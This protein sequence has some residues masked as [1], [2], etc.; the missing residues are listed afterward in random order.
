MAAAVSAVGTLAG[1][2]RARAFFPYVLK[3]LFRKKT[4]IAPDDRARSSCRSS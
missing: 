2:L 3:N 4:R 1:E